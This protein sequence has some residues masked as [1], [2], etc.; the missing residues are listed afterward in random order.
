MKITK[1]QN[2]MDTIF[3]NS[4]N[5]KTSDPHRTLLNLADKINLMRSDNENLMRISK[6]TAKATGDL[7]GNKIAGRITKISKKSQ[8]NNSE[9][10]T[11]N[12]DK[13]IPK[14]GY[15]S[16][17]ERQEIIDELGLKQYNNGITKN[18]NS[19]KKF[20]DSCKQE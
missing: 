20:R 11:N 6:K 13:D 5:I 9:T 19:F 2:R 17:E 15:I 8:Q 14:E 3:M 16:P 4:E 12:Y 10:V 7:I 1:L 18:Y